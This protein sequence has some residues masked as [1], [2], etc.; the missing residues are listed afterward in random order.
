[1]QH[2]LYLIVV[3]A[4]CWTACNTTK[5]NTLKNADYYNDLSN[6][7]D[8]IFNLM[9]GKYSYY[10]ADT[11]AIFSG[12]DSMVLFIVAAGTTNRDGYWIYSEQFLTGLPDE[13]VL[14]SLQQITRISRDT[15]QGVSYVLSEDGKKKYAGL[16]QAPDNPQLKERPMDAVE[17]E[18]GD[19]CPILYI[20]QSNTSFLMRSDTCLAAKEAGYKFMHISGQVS[21]KGQ[22]ANMIAFDEK[23]DTAGVAEA[24]FMRVPYK[25]LPISKE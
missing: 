19:E 25:A 17:K 22:A 21:L 8:R 23:M 9:T 13:P 3:F 4:F 18:G 2:F 1:M 7:H 15:F 6:N 10:E 11:L 5:N 14:Q 20:K 12:K 16:S 24:F